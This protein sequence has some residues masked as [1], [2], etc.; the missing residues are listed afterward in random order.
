MSRH[1]FL[2]VSLRVAVGAA[3]LVAAAWLAGCRPEIG[4][5]CILST[6][7]STRGD[8]LCDTSQPD[9]YCTQFGC[10]KDS[11]PDDGHCVLFN[12]AVPGCGYDDRGGKFGGRTGRSWCVAHCDQQSDCRSGYICANPREAPWGGIVLDNNQRALG[13]MILPELIDAGADAGPDAAISSPKTPAICMPGGQSENGFDASA[14]VIVKD[15]GSD[16]PPL[17]KDS[18]APSVDAGDAGDGGDGGI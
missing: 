11:C 3:A 15:A 7:C 10:Q 18:G 8:R 13:C 2:R 6:D 16:A 12:A 1:A 14:P 17:V 5:K 9:G 4:D